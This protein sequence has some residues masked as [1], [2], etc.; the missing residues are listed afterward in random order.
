MGFLKKYPLLL[1]IIV[2]Y[3]LVLHLWRIDIIP[4]LIN[5]QLRTERILFA[6][7]SALCTI[8]LFFYI[9]RLFSDTKLSLIGIWIYSV[10]PWTIEQGRIISEANLALFIFLIYL[11]LLTLFTSKIIKSVLFFIFLF[12]LNFVYPH[13]WVYQLV[14]YGNHYVVDSLTNILKIFSFGFFF[15][16]NDSFWLG[17]VRNWGIIYLSFL[18]VLFLGVI[19]IIQNHDKKIIIYIL[20]IGILTGF[21]PFYPETREFYLSLP[22]LIIILSK[23]LI[24]LN[25]SSNVFIKI[26]AFCLFVLILYDIAGFMHYYF[27]HYPSDLNNILPNILNKF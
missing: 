2:L 10:I 12:S 17:G 18:P 13:L 22:F 7:F 26:M 11:N 3:S 6:I 5:P 1:I 9:Q 4:S 8:P 16:N 25:N 14:N 23:G 15:F 24:K 19:D 27:V 20:I 21:S